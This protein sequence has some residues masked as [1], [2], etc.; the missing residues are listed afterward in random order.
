MPILYNEMGTY[1]RMAISDDKDGT[2]QRPQKSLAGGKGGR[3]LAV[4]H[5]K[6][7][8]MRFPYKADRKPC[9]DSGGKKPDAAAKAGTHYPAHNP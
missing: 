6:T 7:H 5:P 1:A 9:H 2:F 3:A 4:L 8:H